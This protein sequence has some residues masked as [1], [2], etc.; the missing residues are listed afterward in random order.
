MYV[1]R[2]SVLW[3]T[4][5]LFAAVLVL[6]FGLASYSSAKASAPVPFTVVLDAGHGG[7]DP[8]VL[9]MNTGT[10]ESDINLAIVKILEKYFS[11]A[12]FRV[13]L[14]RKNEGGLYGLPTGG[15]KRRDMQKRKDVIEKT[16]P[17][18]VISV[19]QNNFVSDR[20]RRGGQV[21]FKPGDAEGAALAQAVQQQ[22]NGLSG[23]DYSA[24]RGDY[25][26]LNCTHYPSVI[27]ECGF[28]SNAEDEAL[29]VTEEYRR[30][31]AYAIFK[32]TLAWLS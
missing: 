15:Y 26:M 29:L 5:S 21:F 11:E 6:C 13:V 9:G 1:L 7:I 3:V 22:L 16:A 31:V 24:L 18:A 27:A 23:G 8:G 4:V 30:K 19:H 20:S 12:G 14:T 28:L 2:K 32:G 10:K 25:F 17:N